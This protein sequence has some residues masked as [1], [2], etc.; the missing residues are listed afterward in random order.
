MAFT[1]DQ[2]I[3][4]ASNPSTIPSGGSYGEGTAYN[5]A[6]MLPVL[7]SAVES[8]QMTLADYQKYAQP[9]ATAGQRAVAGISRQGSK[10]ANAVNGAW[11]QLQQ[12]VNGNGTMLMPWTKQQYASLP[13]NV[14]PT[15]DQ[16][17][18]GLFDPS[19]APLSRIQTPATPTGPTTPGGGTQAPQPTQGGAATPA[20][21]NAP[22]PQ[23]TPTNAAD[24]APKTVTAGNNPNTNVAPQ[25]ANSQING[26]P[27]YSANPNNPG[28]NG[29]L[30]VNGSQASQDAGQIADEAALQAQLSTQAQQGITAS[31]NA[32]LNDL[33]SLMDK[34]IN[35]Q[36]QEQMPG[37][38]E[39]LNSRGL[40]RS[41]A[42]GNATATAAGNLIKDN[43]N[44]L[45]TT[46]VN[47]EN[48]DLNNYNT[49]QNI[50]NAG[51]NS[52]L[53]RQ[54]SVEDYQ[55]QLDAGLELGQ[56]AAA[57]KPQVP[58]TKQQAEIGLSSSIGPAIA[59]SGSA[60]AKA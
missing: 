23:F 42:L 1:L 26:A 48:Q 52:A 40:L 4:Y 11:G 13:N 56:Q 22:Q 49:I 14:L 59:A 39:D 27:V 33:T 6:A 32:Y 16:I 53:Q 60:A 9:L 5:V 21:P 45:E 10:Q 25:T 31:R 38:Y 19:T 2:V 54:F 51:R 47:N 24:Q 3:Q 8:G 44:Q 29:G 28:P 58:G 17:N 57:L 36:M 43:T 15:Q 46:A 20:T 34:N 55:N 37:I 12:Y 41:S 50:Y 18:Q 7:K 35:Q 30:V